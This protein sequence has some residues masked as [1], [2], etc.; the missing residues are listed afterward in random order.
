MMR[1]RHKV[2]HFEGRNLRY[3]VCACGMRWERFVKYSG[4]YRHTFF[5]LVQKKKG[6][7]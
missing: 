6:P 5:M 1:C 3:I 4:C 2:L 7:K